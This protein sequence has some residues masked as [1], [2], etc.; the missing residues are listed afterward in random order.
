MIK[1]LSLAL[2]SILSFPLFSEEKGGQVPHQREGDPYGVFLKNT[3][4]SPFVVNNKGVHVL[5]APGGVVKMEGLP[6]PAGRKYVVIEVTPQEE[7]VPRVPQAS[8]S[9][10]TLVKK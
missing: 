5:L 7:A 6:P 2:L 9:E 3:G 10:V 8:S 1:I 4:T